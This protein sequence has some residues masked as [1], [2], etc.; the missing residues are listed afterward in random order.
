MKHL[1]VLLMFTI[2]WQLAGSKIIYSFSYFQ[3]FSIFAWSLYSLRARKK[4]TLRLRFVF[5]HSI[6]IK[7]KCSNEIYYFNDLLQLKTL[8]IYL[9][10][11]LNHYVKWHKVS[12]RPNSKPPFTLDTGHS[13]FT[14]INE[15]S[16]PA[17]INPFIGNIVAP[18][19]G[20]ERKK[21]IIQ[22][23]HSRNEYFVQF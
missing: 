21:L 14:Q 22:I 8:K 3:T 15:I 23:C 5:I 16:K 12:E 13:A 7:L 10:F 11:C 4:D 9:I 1:R 17:R 20:V 19:I 6:A 18:K 2:R